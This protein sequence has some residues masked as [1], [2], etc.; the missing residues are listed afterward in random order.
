VNEEDGPD[1][2][3]EESE[4][5]EEE[6]EGDG[7]EPT[8][9]ARSIRTFESITSVQSQRARK[10]KRFATGRKSL[11]D[12]LAQVPELSRLSGMDAHKVGSCCCLTCHCLIAVS[13]LYTVTDRT[14]SR[15]SPIVITPLAHQPDR[16]TS[17][18]ARAIAHLA[19]AACANVGVHHDVSLPLSELVV[20]DGS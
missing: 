7:E 11:T 20:G 17:I 5:S 3:E 6:Q 18:I 8:H 19:A 1:K 4:E 16:F 10:K 13:I 14:L 9:D 2:T 12:R 15:H